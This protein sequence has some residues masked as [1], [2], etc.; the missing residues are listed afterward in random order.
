MVFPKPKDDDPDAPPLAKIN[1]GVVAR[2]LPQQGVVAI[3]GAFQ[4]GSYVYNPAVHISGGFA[5][6]SIFKQQLK[7]EWVG[8]EAGDFVVTLGGYANNYQPKSYYPQVAR[9]E[10]TWQYSSALSIK[11]LA[12][13]A[14]T[15][16][17]MMAGGH[18]IANFQEG[19][20]FSIHVNFQVGADFIIYWKP[21]HYAAHFWASLDVTASISVD[22]WLFTIHASV[23][24]DLG[25]DLNIWGPE[26]S[27]NGTVH[28]HVLV[29]FSA[30][31]SFGAGANRIQAIDMQ[32][33]QDTLLPDPTDWI[34]K[35]IAAGLVSNESSNGNEVVNPKDLEME[36]GL[37]F[38]MLPAWIQLNGSAVD[39][40]NYIQVGATITLPTPSIGTG[41]TWSLSDPSLAELVGKT[42]LQGLVPGELT[43]TYTTSKNSASYTNIIGET[44]GIKPMEVVADDLAGS[45]LNITTTVPSG[46]SADDIQIAL[47]YE[48][49]PAA[50]WEPTATLNSS[51]D[52]GNR[53]LIHNVV[54]GLH[55]TSAAPTAGNE[56]TATVPE[57]QPIIMPSSEQASAFAYDNFTPTLNP[58]S[59]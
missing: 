57:F 4:P 52:P 3:N 34:S 24:L 50:I 6:L 11:A 7:G 26:F 42:Q 8:A 32:E 12:Y 19:G 35:K 27:G 22:L 21:Y 45:T 9:I 48:N 37:R 31:V 30:S 1:I 49:V 47:V 13:F 44:F 10:M 28:I 58:K 20:C 29:S 54:T 16:Q 5:A 56:D 40:S 33:F 53:D 23:N 43:L 14:L 39:T 2:I 18:L 51:G 59:A 41:G 17:A 55:I 25:A 36:F 15:P 46:A 38:P